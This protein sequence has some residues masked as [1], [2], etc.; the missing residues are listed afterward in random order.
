MSASVCHLELKTTNITS[1]QHATQ[2]HVDKSRVINISSLD[3]ELISGSG[4]MTQTICPSNT[5]ISDSVQS[6]KTHRTGQKK[7][8]KE[9]KR[10]QHDNS[11]HITRYANQTK[12]QNNR[13]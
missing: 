6:L 8:R 2:L 13:Q 11:H 12:S 3:S 10:L 9:Y 1:L 7:K 5:F 4:S